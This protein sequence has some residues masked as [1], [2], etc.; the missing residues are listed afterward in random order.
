VVILFRDFKTAELV[1]DS[2]NIVSSNTLQC[3][4]Q[5]GNEVLLDSVQYE[6]RRYTLVTCGDRLNLY[7][8]NSN[9]LQLM[10]YKSKDNLCWIVFFGTI[11]HH[12]LYF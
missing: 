6:K 10:D 1:V 7:R 3:P 5:N 9:A 4:S 12:C 2:V 11:C 8:L